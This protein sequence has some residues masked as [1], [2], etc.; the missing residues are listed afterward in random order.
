MLYIFTVGGV[1]SV[2]GLGKLTSV[3]SK[4]QSIWLAIRLE[5]GSLL[6]CA[7]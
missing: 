7:K 4:I 1:V 2:L 3:L 5:S 6:G